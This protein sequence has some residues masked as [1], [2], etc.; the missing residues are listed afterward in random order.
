[1]SS[2]CSHVSG[3]YELQMGH[4]M[5]ENL[6]LP[7]NSCFLAWPMKVHVRNLIRHDFCLS[8]IVGLFQNSL[9]NS[10]SMFSLPI[11]PFPNIGCLC[12]HVF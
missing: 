8:V 3:S 5:V 10:L 12:G 9:E 7:K 1:V 4:V 2:T 11:Y 6:C